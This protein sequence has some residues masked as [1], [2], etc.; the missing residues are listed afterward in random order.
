MDVVVTTVIISNRH[1]VDSLVTM[2][3][4]A[5]SRVIITVGST[6]AE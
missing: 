1:I 4:S 2:M 3:G 6:C 5:E